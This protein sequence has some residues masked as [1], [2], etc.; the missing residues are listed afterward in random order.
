MLPYATSACGRTVWVVFLAVGLALS[1]HLLLAGYCH[2]VGYVVFAYVGLSVVV[3]VLSLVVECRIAK[4]STIG[5]IIGEGAGGTGDRRGARP[6]VCYRCDVDH[7]LHV[8][9]RKV[10]LRCVFF[11]F[12]PTGVSL[13]RRKRHAGGGAEQ[14]DVRTPRS[15]Q[16]CE[17]YVQRVILR[18]GHPLS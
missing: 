14:C 1:S 17:A 10:L 8:V 18:D 2:D 12:L 13:Q 15:A 16:R 9:L 5:T 4:A 6:W 3:G 7:R 11:L